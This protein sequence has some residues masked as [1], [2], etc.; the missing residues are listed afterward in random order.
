MSSEINRSCKCQT[1]VRSSLTFK[2]NLKKI[3]FWHK[4]V[5]QPTNKETNRASLWACWKD[6][7]PRSWP[8]LALSSGCAAQERAG[9]LSDPSGTFSHDRC[10]FS[11]GAS[12]GV[13]TE[14][15]PSGFPG[16]FRDIF[17]LESLGNAGSG[18]H[19]ETRYYRHPG[20]LRLNPHSVVV[21]R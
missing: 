13:I 8:Q 15:K 17:K 11:G 3:Q 20:G 6:G 4:A 19:I 14:R 10:R 7:P 1:G 9:S 21:T 5:S 18:P 16:A 12:L 2:P